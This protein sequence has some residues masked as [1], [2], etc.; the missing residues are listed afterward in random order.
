MKHWECAKKYN[1]R[2]GH[3]KYWVSFVVRVSIWRVGGFKQN[4][5]E[6]VYIISDQW[7]NQSHSHHDITD[8]AGKDFWLSC[9]FFVILL[10]TSDITLG[11]TSSSRDGENRQINLRKYNWFKPHLHAIQKEKKKTK[12]WKLNLRN[13]LKPRSTLFEY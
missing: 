7:V 1:T 10:T 4:Q 13:K 3:S 5:P 12:S 11:H 9:R 6:S 8:S 2:A